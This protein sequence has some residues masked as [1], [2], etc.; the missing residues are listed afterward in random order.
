MAWNFYI[1]IYINDISF[2]LWCPD[3]KY[4]QFA[5]LLNPCNYH[6]VIL[7]KAMWV[8][9]IQ[10]EYSCMSFKKKILYVWIFKILNMYKYCP[11]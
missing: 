2:Y 6:N 9:C 10:H 11:Y 8:L 7:H 1:Y 5:F 3:M 4:I